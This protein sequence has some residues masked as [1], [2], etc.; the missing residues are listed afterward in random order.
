MYLFPV[1]L[2]PLKSREV[3]ANKAVHSQCIVLINLRVPLNLYGC[4]YRINTNPEG[5]LVQP[6]INQCDKNIP[7]ELEQKTAK[8]TVEPQ[9]TKIVSKTSS[10]CGIIDE[11]HLVNE[12]VLRD[13]NGSISCSIIDGTPHSKLD[14]IRKNERE[15]QKER[16]W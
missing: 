10:V 6:E 5:K 8:Y 9:V 16:A 15:Q 11:H 7:L 12:N 4:Q 2:E 1:R 13:G 14:R 3:V